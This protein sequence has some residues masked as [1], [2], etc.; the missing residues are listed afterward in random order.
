VRARRNQPTLLSK[1]SP[2][3]AKPIGHRFT[4][5]SGTAVFHPLMRRILFRVSSLIFSSKTP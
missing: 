2:D 5:F 3:F 4:V 1:R